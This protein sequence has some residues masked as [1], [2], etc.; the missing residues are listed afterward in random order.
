MS[1]E[2]EGCVEVQN[3]AYE[4]IVVPTQLSGANTLGV[5]ATERRRLN[6]ILI[7]CHKSMQE[8]RGCIES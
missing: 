8:G 6:V 7:K 5:R 3:F 1:G 4:G 2:L